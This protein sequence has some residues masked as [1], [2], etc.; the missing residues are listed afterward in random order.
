MRPR[1]LRNLASWDIP[2][3]LKLNHVTFLAKAA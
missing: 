3:M 1:Y 2:E